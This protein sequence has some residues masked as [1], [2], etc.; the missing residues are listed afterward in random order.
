MSV[1][2]NNIGV[3]FGRVQYRV[4]VV[5][6]CVLRWIG[7]EGIVNHGVGVVEVA[8]VVA[9]FCKM[10]CNRW[11]GCWCGGGEMLYE[12]RVEG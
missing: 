10:F 5:C 12:D 3:P 6:E 9:R 8:W 4:E 1:R 7:G 11:P 2:Q